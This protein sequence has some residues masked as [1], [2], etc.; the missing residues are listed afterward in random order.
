[1]LCAANGK[2]STGVRTPIVPLLVLWTEADPS[3]PRVGRDLVMLSAGLDAFCYTAVRLGAI[4][5]LDKDAERRNRRVDS[6]IQRVISSELQFQ[7]RYQQGR[8]RTE[9]NRVE[10]LPFFHPCRQHPCRQTPV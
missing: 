6:K 7:T 5:P 10:G 4:L 8:G 3:T 9:G 2:V 1:M